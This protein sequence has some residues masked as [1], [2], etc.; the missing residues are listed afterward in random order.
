MIGDVAFFFRLC[1]I[2]VA[3]A[4]QPKLAELLAVPAAHR[5]APADAAGAL[6]QPF[7]RKQAAVEAVEAELPIAASAG[8]P[9]GH[10]E[11]AFCARAGPLPTVPRLKH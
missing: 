6:H 11:A 2:A 8:N 9:G 4:Q 5:A 1:P 3:Q 7:A 10:M